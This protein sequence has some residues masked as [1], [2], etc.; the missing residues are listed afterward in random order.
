M[1]LEYYKELCS[2]INKNKEEKRRED[3]RDRKREQTHVKGRE[4]T[5]RFVIILRNH[6]G[7][8]ERGQHSKRRP[9]EKMSLCQPINYY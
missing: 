5:R 7:T 4:R 2:F 1:K 6:G 8:L 3:R 9:R